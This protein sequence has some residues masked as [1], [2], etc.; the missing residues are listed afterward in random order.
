MTEY[1]RQEEMKDKNPTLEIGT[2]HSFCRN[3][4]KGA[5]PDEKSHKTVL[6]YGEQGKGC[7]IK[8]TQ[9]TTGYAGLK[10]RVKEMRPDLKY[11]DWGEKV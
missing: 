6:G 2:W 5:N 9:V 1:N 8:W 10:E 7:G 3:C 4:G 11:V